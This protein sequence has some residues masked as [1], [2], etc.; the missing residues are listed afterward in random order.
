MSKL[1][2]V[3]SLRKLFPEDKN[4]IDALKFEREH[5]NIVIH[6]VD[7]PSEEI[8]VKSLLESCKKLGLKAKSLEMF[9]KDEPTNPEDAK[10]NRIV[11]LLKCF[12]NV[13]K[14]KLVDHTTY[15]EILDD[16]LSSSKN[17]KLSH[18]LQKL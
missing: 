15:T 13:K 3:I 6:D 7:F 12:T 10:S 17:L 2:L 11:N 8:K 18:Q 9:V 4:A 16:D 14:L 1:K 5:L